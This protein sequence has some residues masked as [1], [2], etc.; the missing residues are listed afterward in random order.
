MSML[1]TRYTECRCVFCS[2]GMGCRGAHGVEGAASGTAAAAAPSAAAA[3]AAAADPPAPS[4]A[5]MVVAHAEVW[6]ARVAPGEVPVVLE[7]ATLALVVL[8]P[9]VK[10]VLIE[11]GAKG[12]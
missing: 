3:V 4:V 9:I 1:G 7:V 11:P 12:A 6:A 10:G 2:R 5:V 8:V